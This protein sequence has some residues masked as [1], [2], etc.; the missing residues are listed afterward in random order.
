MVGRKLAANEREAKTP[1]KVWDIFR[2]VMAAEAFR[3]GVNAKSATDILSPFFE[4]S[5]AISDAFCSKSR[6][7]SRSF[8]VSLRWGS[9][10]SSSNP[11]RSSLSW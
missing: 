2:A 6:E 4:S 8:A 5:S 9:S 7:A 1:S 10:I 3:R 11:F